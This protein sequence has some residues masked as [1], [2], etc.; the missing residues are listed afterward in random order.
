MSVKKEHKKCEEEKKKIKNAIDNL[1]KNLKEI[2]KQKREKSKNDRNNISLIIKGN[3]NSIY[4][5]PNLTE[6]QKKNIKRKKN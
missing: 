2:R 6:D 1:K 5:N 3:I 4:T